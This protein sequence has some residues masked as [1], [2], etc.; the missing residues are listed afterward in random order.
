MN[1]GYAAVRIADD[2]TQSG[3]VNRLIAS[4]SIWRTRAGLQ[5]IRSAIS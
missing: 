3:V 4:F 1:A 5:P 2:S